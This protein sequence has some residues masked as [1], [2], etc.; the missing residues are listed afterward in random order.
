[1]NRLKCY[2]CKAELED[3][4]VYEYR[5]IYSCSDHFDEACLRRDHQRSE[6]IKEESAKTEVF[7]GLDLSDSVIGRA[8]KDILKSNIEIASKESGRIKDYEGKQTG[9]SDEPS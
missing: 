6:I 8:N 2:V 9:G 4:D 3:C 7:R 5:G 1:M